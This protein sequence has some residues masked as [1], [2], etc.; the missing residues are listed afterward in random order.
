MLSLPIPRWRLNHF[1][2]GED[3]V[4]QVWARTDSGTGGGGN[5]LASANE[6]IMHKS[7]GQRCPNLPHVAL[8]ITAVLAEMIALDALQELI[9]NCGSAGRGSRC[10]GGCGGRR[11]RIGGRRRVPAPGGRQLLPIR[12][13][14]GSSGTHAIRIPGGSSGSAVQRLAGHG[15]RIV[16]IAAL[17]APRA[18]HRLSIDFGIVHAHNGMGGRLLG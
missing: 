13:S 17:L 3:K 16:R 5:T 4:Q 14:G 15:L 12:S 6:I 11:G 9:L 1:A 10:D 2:T 8:L 18:L 7:N